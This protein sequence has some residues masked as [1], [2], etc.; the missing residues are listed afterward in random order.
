M[1]AAAFDRVGVAIATGVLARDTQPVA[2]SPQFGIE[3]T[4][5]SPGVALIVVQG[6]I[7]LYTTPPFREMV[8]HCLSREPGRIVMDLSR[9]TFLDAA[10]LGVVVDTANRMELDTVTVVCPHP[11][12][13]RILRLAGLDRVLAL[14]A[15][16]NESAPRRD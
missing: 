1:E 15:S 4:W 13:V 16:S 8:A 6:E 12:I 5:P 9:V 7:D 3:L 10:G 11:L 2:R 14:C